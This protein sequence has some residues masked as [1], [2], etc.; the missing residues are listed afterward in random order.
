[1]SEDEV[2]CHKEIHCSNEIKL[3]DTLKRNDEQ[4]T[5]MDIHDINCNLQHFFKLIFFGR[6]N[7]ILESK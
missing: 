1:M 4:M 2:D 7:N 6:S 3:E 5:R